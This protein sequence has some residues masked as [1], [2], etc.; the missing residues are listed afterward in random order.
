MP[1][2]CYTV[3]M[4]NKIVN[5]LILC[6]LI[7]FVGCGRSDPPAIQSGIQ[8]LFRIVDATAD[9]GQFSSIKLNENGQPGISYYDLT[10]GDLKFAQLEPAGTWD[11]TVV[12]EVGD[13]G[14]YS[15]LQFASTG[16]P[17]IAYYDVTNRRPKYAYYNGVEWTFVPIGYPRQGGQYIDMVLDD[18][19]IARLSFISE[20]T[21]NLEYALYLAG[22]PD[23][24]GFT[25]DEGTRGTGRG[26]NVSQNTCIQLRRDGVE[27]F[28]V[29]VYYQ[30]SYG[31][32]M[33]A[34]FDPT[35]PSAIATGIHTGWVYRVLDGN[36]STRAGEDVGMWADCSLMGDQLH[37]SYFD[38]T[39]ENQKYAFVDLATD[40]LYNETVD[41]NGLLGQGSSVAVN[42]DG[43]AHIAYYDATNNDLKLALRTPR[44]WTT[45]RVDLAGIVG[46]FP[47][48][49]AFGDGQV[50]ISYQ[51]FGAHALKF[52]LVRPY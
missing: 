26:G 29:I 44:G 39:A 25:I 52:A 46:T 50:G 38:A 21:F 32:L 3:C 34:Y 40:E 12:D 35:H 24:Q 11:I 2:L 7:A 8:A 30:A 16:Y 27:Q 47:S 10:N 48:M 36:Y 28:P 15:S 37:V 20:G 23:A 4:M 22:Q 13:V 17:H 6:A 14:K 9:V 33:L 19:D 42:S 43:L 45:R 51:D 41:N 1:G 5:T 49:I 31:Q 18:N